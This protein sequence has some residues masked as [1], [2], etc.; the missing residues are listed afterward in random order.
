[1][2]TPTGSPAAPE[3]VD[4]CQLR[5]SAIVMSGHALS[6]VPNRMEH[7]HVPVQSAS[8]SKHHGLTPTIRIHICHP[9]AEG[10]QRGIRLQ[11]SR[12]VGFSY[13]IPMA[14]NNHSSVCSGFSGRVHSG[15]DAQVGGD[16]ALPDHGPDVSLRRIGVGGG[17]WKVERRQAVRAEHLVRQAW[18]RRLSP[19]REPDEPRPRP[20][21]AP[22][23]RDWDGHLAGLVLGAR[24]PAGALEHRRYPGGLGVLPRC[25]QGCLIARPRAVT[26]I[27]QLARSD[28]AERGADG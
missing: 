11:R 7:D 17:I 8:M 23:R 10:T 19:E 3:R 20:R 2:T 1:M 27:P 21:K 14:P 16:P 6:L 9:R 24:W 25:G 5:I 13:R 4:R 28:G 15:A 22:P 26:P 18:L 12:S